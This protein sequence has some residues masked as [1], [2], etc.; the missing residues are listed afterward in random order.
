M[1]VGTTNFTINNFSLNQL[2][3]EG[4]NAGFLQEG[5]NANSEARYIDELLAYPDDAFSFQLTVP[6]DSALYGNSAG[7]IIPYAGY[8]FYPTTASNSRSDY[9]VFQ[10]PSLPRMQGEGEQPIFAS[11]TEKYPLIVYSH[12]VGDHPT[13]DK[14]NLFSTLASHGYIVMALYHGDYR[15]SQ[16]DPQQ[17]NLRPLAVKTA[18]D[19]LLSDPAFTDHIDVNKIGG[20]GESYGGSTMLALLGAKKLNPDT[21]SVISN[22]L[23]TTT[24]D[25]RIKAAATIV[26]YAG[27]GIYPFF[28]SGG[29]GVSQISRPFMANSATVDAETDLA[30]VQQVINNLTGT[31]YLIE[32]E[33]EGHELSNGAFQDANTW[34][35]IFLD[36]FVK[37]D[38]DALNTLASIQSVS[39]SGQDSLTVVTEPK[40]APSTAVTFADNQLIVPGLIAGTDKYDVT[41]T[42]L[43]AVEP[44]TF[45]LTDAVPSSASYSAGSYSADGVLSIPVV[46]VGTT[47]Y[48]VS[49]SLTSMDPIV[50]TLTGAEEL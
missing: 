45:S 8:I 23:L 22:N 3:S 12:G 38:P 11:D 39:S 30:M 49:F 35:K 9:D 41:L 16:F 13:G 44:I 17:F 46:L 31:K 29:T 33:G 28:G 43:S 7:T 19:E 40:P 47:R 32:Y 34:S 5:Y 42:V 48:S 4:L 6:N 26:P 24:T 20:M 21:A 25:E 14:I 18:I 2:L 15:Y 37:E 36:A 50:F 27:A 10:P 1:K